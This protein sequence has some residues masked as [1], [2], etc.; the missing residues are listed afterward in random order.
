MAIIRIATAV[1]DTFARFLCAAIVLKSGDGRRCIGT[2][3]SSDIAAGFV[4]A[5]DHVGRVGK[6]RTEPRG[7]LVDLIFRLIPVH[8]DLHRLA[9]DLIFDQVRHRRCAGGSDAEVL[10]ALMAITVDA[11]AR[12]P[13]AKGSVVIDGIL[14]LRVA[15]IDARFDFA[16]I[17]P[18]ILAEG[19]VSQDDLALVGWVAGHGGAGRVR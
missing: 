3:G 4:I 19:F 7:L 5:L 6:E 8:H 10:D 14:L 11:V 18:P 1:G 2:S 16:A 15:V 12:S 9:I 13:Y 17:G